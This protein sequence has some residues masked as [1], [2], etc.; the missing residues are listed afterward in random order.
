MEP[1]FLVPG[2]ASI[3]GEEADICCLTDNCLCSTPLA[4]SQPCARPFQGYS[5]CKPINPFAIFHVYS[6]EMR[7]AP[8]LSPDYH[9][10]IFSLYWILLLF[11]D[12]PLIR[13]LQRV[14]LCL[15]FV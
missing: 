12:S 6:A 15:S 2:L 13:G 11:A 1:L 5:S 4:G 3:S 9:I 8:L 7:G 10:P 14:T